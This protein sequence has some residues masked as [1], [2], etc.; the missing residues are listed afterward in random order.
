M[1][2]SS[3]R[4]EAS[5]LAALHSDCILDTPAEPEFDRIAQ[6]AADL[7]DAP[8][9]LISL[10][11]AERQWFKA[12]VGLD[13]RSTPPE[14]AFCAHALAMQPGEVLVVDDP[15]ADPRFADNP[16]VLGAP[17]IRFYAGAL[18]TDGAGANLG[19]LCVIDTKRRAKPGAR[20]LARLRR[21]AEMVVDLLE[22]LRSK[23]QLEVER[24]RLAL[25]ERD[26]AALTDTLEARVAE[27]TA[28]LTAEKERLRVSEARLHDVFA[29]AR[30]AI[31]VM[32]AQG[33]IEDWNR[34]AE[35][36]FGWSA[37]HA[38]GRPLGA[39]L[40]PPALQAAHERGLQR[41]LKAGE[42]KV[43]GQRMELTALHKDGRELDIEL[44]ISASKGADGWRFT[45]L[46]HD[47]SDRKAQ[48]ELFE[49][50]FNHA[51]IGFALVGLDGRFLKVNGAFGMLTGYEAA[52]L[53]ACDFQSITHPDDLDRD[54]ELLSLLTA[55]AIP[56]YQMD[57][58]YIRADGREV[59][60]NLSVSMVR[61]R[62]GAPRHYI[63]QVQDL[64][65]RM[66]AEAR[67]QLIADKITDM[68]VTYDL[69]G[70]T[71]FVSAGCRAIIGWT[72]AEAIG[73]ET[74]E[75]VHPQ[76]VPA[77]RK[78]FGRAAAGEP[79]ER[80]RW[81]GWNRDREQWMWL[82]SLPS[83]LTEGHERCF[84]D[85][86]RDV[87]SQVAQEEALTAARQAAEAAAAA[88][89]DFL[90]NMSHEIR[91]PLTA[92]IGFSGLLCG[93]EDLTP[94][95]RGFAERI[96]T[97]GGALLSV[98]N[99]ILDFSKLEAGE[100]EI[101]PRAT[102]ALTMCRDILG[103]FKPQADSKGLEL[104]LAVDEPVPALVTLDPQALRQ[105]LFN[106]IS[107]AVK[108]TERGTV[109]LRLAHR[110]ERM[111]VAVDDTGDGVSVEQQA[112]LFQRF[113]QVDSSMTRKHG[114]TGLGLA[115]CKGL[116]EAM[117]GSIDVTSA[118]GRGASFRFDI[119]APEAAASAAWADVSPGL[120]IEGV[121]VLVSDDN[122]ANR[123]LAR[124]I[125]ESLGA[126]VHEAADGLGAVE[127]AQSHSLDVI[128]MAMSMPRL[129]GPGAVARIRDERGPNRDIP[130]LAFSAGEP[131]EPPPQGF[132]G[133]V[134]EPVT[135]AALLRAI[136]AALQEPIAMQEISRAHG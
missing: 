94:G 88:K 5:R 6:M 53:L 48:T 51:P 103:L 101:R 104:R 16:L 67:F 80:V 111:T 126:E 60:V 62:S 79:P 75:F 100:V 31:V 11:D 37:E 1:T 93:R 129:D 36:T 43:V 40:I 74:T 116:V 119:L 98:V 102:D 122:D 55:G 10:V 114:G 66:E 12:V 39:L 92:V 58:R 65:D 76:D 30:E 20:E 136:D 59:W 130:I 47:I 22:G 78:A 132:D 17:R 27:R 105:V 110:G 87:T 68:I 82:E 63:A 23:R 84:V 33:C 73:R 83:L 133:A 42:G 57:K 25:R 70:R 19:T 61:E 41:F 56:H 38:V 49:N 134:S 71:T 128:L 15:L 131:G 2:S 72:P 112:K 7:F 85:V 108:F 4:D 29:D 69:S 113:S 123:G 28:A 127:V 52:A 77:M 45:G 96:S 86:V 64:T 32:D 109:T 9:A 46:M 21:L 26:L 125:L 95:A 106:L 54:L 107:N 120:S 99:G 3:G 35:L 124:A 14:Q 117:G 97:A 91:T 81:R 135:P 121:R 50:A 44:A 89:A 13:V 115:I 24:E 90:A 18:L 118:P 8:I 34:G